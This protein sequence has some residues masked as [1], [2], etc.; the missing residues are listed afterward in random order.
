MTRR[1]PAGALFAAACAVLTLG[2]YAEFVLRPDRMLFGTDMLD[3]AYHLRAFAVE[4]LKAGRGFPLWNPF[5]YGGLPYLAILPGPVFYPTSLLYLVLPLHR[6]IGWTFVLHTFLSGVFA[7]FAARALGLGRS[8]AA[9][10]GISFLLTGF[11]VS[12]LYGGH[13]GRMF[14]MVLTPLAFACLEKGLASGRVAW[15]AGFG[16]VVALQ[17]FTPHVQLMYFSSLLLLFYALVRIAMLAREE[18]RSRA[19][20]AGG[21]VAGAFVLA[22]LVGAAQ[23]VPTWRILEIAVRG[24]TGEAG[25]GFAASW[26]LPPGELTALVLPDLLGSLET[27]RGANPFKLHTEYLGAVPVALALVGLTRARRDGRVAALGALA[28]LGLLFALGAATPVH[29]LAFHLIPFISRFRAPSMMLG[30]VALFVALLAAFGW[31][32]IRAARATQGGLPWVGLLVAAA[33]LL[34]LGLAAALA[35]AG[36]MRWAGTALVPAGAGAPGE[37]ATGALRLNGLLLLAGLGLVGA[38]ARGVA[39]GR[40]PE[41]A[42]LLAV[43][44]LL[45]ADLWRVDRRYLATLTPEEAFPAAESIDRMRAELAPGERV[46]PVPGRRTF[47]PN[48]LMGAR[49]PSVTGSQNFRL[50]WTER[51]T[52]GL[53]YRNLGDPGL[54]PL[55]DLRFVVTDGPVESPLLEPVS[56]GPRGVLHEVA[57]DGPHA[58]FPAA[59]RATR[60]TAAALQAVLRA[61]RPADAVVVET[62]RAPPAGRGAARVVRWEPDAVDL[63]VEAETGGLLF[64]SEIWHPAW[65]AEL[66]GGEELEVLRANV[67]FRAVVVPEGRHVVR[68]R[69]APDEFRLGFTLTGLGLA[70]ALAVLLVPAVRRWRV[71]GPGRVRDAG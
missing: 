3:Q 44:A 27:Y 11:V 24:G 12:T 34:L 15:F 62:D 39:S 29:R 65:R 10:A 26:A 70:A 8:A 20:H 57:G 50:E 13:D 21:A 6:A 9:V 5:V 48:E 17:I 36:M 38:A 33:P 47:G 64:V 54:W 43:L 51:L 45:V 14:V 52:G 2:F 31:E 1:P 32:R 59:V 49:V 46:F 61:E 63:E 7:W 35:P 28:A 68:F 55:F 69:Y 40:W 25:Y 60:D 67:A 23:L 16:L 4:E 19:V 58:W 71:L 66:E 53:S 30:P 18:G 22:A 41:P 42:A 37:A 56:A